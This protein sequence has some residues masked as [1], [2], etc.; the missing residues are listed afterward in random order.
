MVSFGTMTINEFQFEPVFANSKICLDK[1]C[2]KKYVYSET[3]QN[4]NHAALVTI[5]FN[6]HSNNT[7]LS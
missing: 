7:L 5:F 2:N 3:I 6:Y 4:K 1:K